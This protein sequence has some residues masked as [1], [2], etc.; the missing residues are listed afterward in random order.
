MKAITP[1]EALNT[2][3]TGAVIDYINSEIKGRRFHY[4][5]REY[6]HINVLHY[7]H[8][9]VFDEVVKLLKEAG[10]DAKHG[11]DYCGHGPFYS[12]VIRSND[13]NPEKIEYKSYA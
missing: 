11:P 12:I 4:N 8:Y 10:W 3:H 5:S 1:Q 13:F 2:D 6:F 9:G 7:K